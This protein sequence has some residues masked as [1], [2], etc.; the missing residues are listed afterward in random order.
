MLTG[1]GEEDKIIKCFDDIIGK[2][3]PWQAVKQTREPELKYLREL[4]VSQKVDEHAAVAKYIVTPIDTKWIDTDRAVEEEPMQVRPRTVA[5]E[6]KSGDR[7]DLYTETPPLEEMKAIISIAASHS[8]EFSLVHVD[9]SRAY[10]ST[11]RLRGL[12]W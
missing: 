11:P 9:V 2:E 7:P 6:F 1:A 8:P 3:L 10:F 12:C 4:G 5:R